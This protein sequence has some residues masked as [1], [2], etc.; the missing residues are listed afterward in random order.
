MHEFKES[1]PDKISEIT[2]NNDMKIRIFSY[3]ETRF[4]LITSLGK[5]ITLRGFRPVGLI[6]RTF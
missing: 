4:G 2:Y 1:L 5:R 3:D 6:Q